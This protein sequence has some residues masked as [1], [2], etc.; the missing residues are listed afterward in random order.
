MNLRNK[1]LLVISL[2]VLSCLL[3]LYLI[4]RLILLASFEQIEHRK[5]QLQTEQVKALLAHEAEDLSLVSATLKHI[6]ATNSQLLARAATSI[7]PQYIARN[8][9]IDLIAIIDDQS[10]DIELAQTSFLNERQGAGIETWRPTLQQLPDGVQG[11]LMVKHQPWLVTSNHMPTLNGHKRLLL[12]RLIDTAE[13]DKIN[14]AV[15]SKVQVTAETN[16]QT[17]VSWPSRD[18]IR[19]SI[20]LEDALGQP[21]LSLTLQN[22]TEILA[23]GRQSVGLFLVAATISGLILLVIGLLLQETLLFRRLL[24]LI[25]ELRNIGQT[26]ITGQRVTVI[27]KDELSELA[28]AINQ[29]LENLE[30]SHRLVRENEQQLDELVEAI[31]DLVCFKDAQGRWRR[32]NHNGLHL[33]GLDKNE[34]IGKTNEEVANHNHRHSAGNSLALALQ[35]SSSKDPDIKASGIQTRFEIEVDFGQGNRWLDMIKTPLFDT[36]SGEYKG[37]VVLGRD[38]TDSKLYQEAK[39]F[40]Q[41]FMGSSE[42]IMITDPNSVI[43]MVNTAFTRIT[44]YPPEECLGHTPALLQSGVHNKAFYGKLWQSVRGQGFWEGEVWNRNRD[45]TV[46]AQRLTIDAV[47]DQGG[48]IINYIA[49]LNDISES[50]A[51]EAIIERQASYDSLT[52]LPNRNL[53][54]DRLEQEMAGTR[55][56]DT[57]MAVVFIDL[58][59]FKAVNDSLGHDHGDLLLKSVTERLQA[60]VRQTDTVARLSG[61]EF[62]LILTNLTQGSDSNRVCEQVLAQLNMPFQ[63]NAH[64]VHI[65]GSLGIALYPGDADSP[66]ALLKRADTAMYRAKKRGR[67]QYCYF[68]L[69]M[70]EQA[71]SRA[72]LERDLRAALHLQ[73]FTLHYQPVVDLASGT[74]CGVEALLRWQ[75]PERGF[76][77]PATFIPFA[78]Q[79]GLIRELGEWVLWQACRDIA[80]VR[81]RFPH[82]GYVAVNVSA[83]QWRLQDM[84][85]L[86]GQ[87]LNSTGLPAQQLVLEITEQSFIDDLAFVSR[88]L[89]SLQLMDVRVLL[90]DFGTGYS[91]LSYL[92]RLPVHGLKIDRSFIHDVTE[93][94]E[95]AALV[96]ATLAI[97]DSMK[98][99]V[100]AEGVETSQQRDWLLGEDVRHAQ[101]YLYARPMPLDELLALLEATHGRL[102]I[103]EQPLQ[104]VSG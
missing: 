76:I 20:P 94:P 74:I 32:I 34:V 54:Q 52:G 9:D 96:R 19:S 100:V 45:G 8:P 38:I 15:G 64:K 53:L 69:E 87:V 57:Q 58:D 27:G 29:G 22:E 35:E 60:C 61:D 7:L 81:R 95:G 104:V 98:L 13:L 101:G 17:S 67:S 83:R 68:A 49:I 75:H 14:A 21:T 43:L 25:K 85:A 1:T 42:G 80:D 28:Q 78:E 31:P 36:D 86:V 4:A 89:R 63:L 51:A 40:K 72:M 55:R 12:A 82:L 70:E 30:N 97:A 73:Q 2:T 39:L 71:Q 92:K 91:S 46:Y 5:I 59:K 48:R 66:E 6:L 77:S 37:M 90:D 103:T 33:I 88:E 47:R 11:L 10:G 24:V 93:H 50:K 62:V 84:S 3:G 26:D 16:K 65:S 56:H 23:S 79:N 102:T 44:G 18:L 41:V 99:A